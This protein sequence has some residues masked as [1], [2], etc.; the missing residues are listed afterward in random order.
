MECALFVFSMDCMDKISGTKYPMLISDFNR[1][2]E[3]EESPFK[4]MMIPIS[5]V[6]GTGL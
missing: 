4:S 1:S 6:W 3:E 5:S 2:Y